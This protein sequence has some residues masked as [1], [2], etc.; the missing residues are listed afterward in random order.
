MAAQADIDF[1]KDLWSAAV[2]L[3][4]TVGPA[5]YK[6]YVL[7]LLSLRYLSLRYEARQAQLKRLLADPKSDYHTGDPEIDREILEDPAEYAAE[8]VFVVPEEASWE[9]NA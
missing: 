4:G 1:E 3:R 7:P 6:H 8:N 2:S 9:R 5:D